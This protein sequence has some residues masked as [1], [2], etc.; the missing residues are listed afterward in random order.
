MQT[1]SMALFSISWRRR[2]YVLIFMIIQCSVGLL[3]P[4]ADLLIEDTQAD[5][6]IAS[7]AQ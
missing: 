5:V 2:R 3:H 4:E 6:I 1:T 7:D